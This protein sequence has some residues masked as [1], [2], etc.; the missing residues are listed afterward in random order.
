MRL[1]IIDDE[2]SARETAKML[3]DFEA[4]GFNDLFEAGNGEEALEII[5]NNKPDLIIT[6]M[7]MPRLDGI[8][9]LDVLNE[10][11]EQ[12]K[13]IVISG[14]S[15][16]EYTKIAIKSKVVDYLLKPIKQEELS[17]AVRKAIEE[18]H[19]E[20]FDHHSEPLEI[21][22]KISLNQNLLY[23]NS[24]ESSVIFEYLVKDMDRYVLILIKPL[25][26]HEIEQTRYNGISDLLFYSVDNIIR[27]QLKDLAKR[28][29]VKPM[30][31]NRELIVSFEAVSEENAD[32]FL[33]S[34]QQLGRVINDK[35]GLNCLMVATMDTVSLENTPMEFQKM[36]QILKN[37]NLLSGK[38]IHLASLES[39]NSDSGRYSISS[40]EEIVLNALKYGDEEPIKLAIEAL[41]KEISQYGIVSI[42]ELELLCIEFITIM[43]KGLSALGLNYSL[44][45]EGNEQ[46]L[47][48]IKYTGN[49]E[50]IKQ[51]MIQF[52]DSVTSKVLTLKKEI[53]GAAF[54][55]ILRYIDT[56]YY[57]KI[58]LEL[59]SKKFFFSREYIS[60]QFKKN[61]GENFVEYITRLRLEKAKELL[62]DDNLKLQNISC[63]IGFNDLSYFSKVFK[64]QYGL[65][66]TEYK[67]QN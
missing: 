17:G 14:Y 34:L 58:D 11:E 66:P 1:L 15:D 60:K 36:R 64:K 48:F 62:H 27:V 26:F 47:G 24:D 56:Y 10:R 63:M 3:V 22:S 51:W 5:N 54:N 37:S 45:L 55:D 13:V 31:E 16:F 40:K 32:A 9:L 42:S 21:L 49:I 7:K 61:L 59:L 8:G 41:F 65:S 6:D 18:M 28:V 23:G 35:M 33:L 2:R 19:R 43:N 52:A 67:A 53:G 30:H 4:I 29:R 46:V 50:Q 39:L 57:E 20:K 25:N 38:K 12:F 44:A